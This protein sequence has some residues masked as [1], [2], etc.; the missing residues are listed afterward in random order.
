VN[1]IE[2]FLITAERALK[3]KSFDVNKSALALVVLKKMA[4]ERDN[5][6]K[7]RALLEVG[8]TPTEISRQLNVSRATVYNVRDKETVDRKQGSGRKAVL[9]HQEVK[10]TIEEAPL[11]SMRSHAKDMGVSEAT[12][13]RAVKKL[14]GKSLVR[15]ERPLLTPKMKETHLQRCQ[16]LLNNLKKAPA[17]RV[18]IFS[19]EKS[20]TVDPVRNRKND[21]YLSFGDVNESIRTLSTTKH[22]ASAMSLGF[23]ASNGLKAPLIWFKTGFRLTAA[24]YIKVLEDKFLPWVRTNFPDGNV[25]LQQDGAPAHTANVTQKWLQENIPFWPKNLWPPYSPDANPLD[26]SFWVHV[27]SKAC[28]IRHANVEAMKASVNEHWDAMSEDFIR[29]TCRAFRR[30]IEAIIGAN[31]GYIDD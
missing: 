7:I 29:S 8:Q 6:I 21:R 2:I 26:F 31:G 20:W 23:V 27:E 13:R 22:P 10:R 30:R 19:D 16:A 18:I 15:V 24:E 17:N 11:K 14:G 5:R 25:V 9:D 1:P 3:N 28:S 4:F 12:V